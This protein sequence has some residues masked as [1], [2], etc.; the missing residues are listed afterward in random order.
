VEVEA[1]LR[2][3][4]DEA[5]A[6]QEIKDVRAADAEVGD[7]EYRR[8]ATARRLV[9]I[10]PRLVPL[11]D[12]HARRLAGL[13]LDRVRQEAV[14]IPHA[15]DVALEL[16]LPLLVCFGWGVGGACAAVTL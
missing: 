8:P 5:A 11:V 12:L 13:R 4:L 10:E 3:V 16:V 9:A 15:A 1:L 7:E 14:K 6:R 2:H